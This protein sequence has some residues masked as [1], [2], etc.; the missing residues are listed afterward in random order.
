MKPDTQLK[1]YLV[2]KKALHD[3]GNELRRE[4]EANLTLADCNQMRAPEKTPK[5]GRN[6]FKQTDP[7]PQPIINKLAKKETNLRA[8]NLKRK[9]Y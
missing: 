3:Q 6:A 4:V 9:Y 2:S 5:Q 8:N 7:T 1:S